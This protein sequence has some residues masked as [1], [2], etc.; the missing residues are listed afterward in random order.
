[1]IKSS[2]NGLFNNLG[3]TAAGLDLSLGFFGKSGSFH[4]E[5]LGKLTVRKDLDA[6]KLFLDKA[7]FDESGSVDDSAVIESVLKS[8]YVDDSDFLSE[9]VVEASLGE[10]SL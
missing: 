3:S 2:K 9:D 4:Y 6:V 10:S 5:L 1:M 8:S 7:L